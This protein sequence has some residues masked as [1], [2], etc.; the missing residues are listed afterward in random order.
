M[1]EVNNAKER[2]L[3]NL[4][5]ALRQNR[6]LPDGVFS[7]DWSEFLFFDSDRIFDPQFVISA[8]ALLEIEGGIWACMSNLDA[9]SGETKEQSLLFIHREMTGEAYLKFLREEGWVYGMD[10]YGCTSDI[11]KW[12]IYCEKGNE[13]AVLAGREHGSLKKFESVISQ[14]R[15]VPIEQAVEGPLSYGFSPRAL[16]SEWRDELLKRYANSLL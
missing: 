7:A 10:R 3:A 12:C 16:S 1:S 5:R 8:I 11:A 6:R 15:A 2:A 13:I 9:S 4:T 14:L